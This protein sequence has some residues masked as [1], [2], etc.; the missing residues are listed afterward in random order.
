MLDHDGILAAVDA[1]VHD[2]IRVSANLILK[3]GQAEA[4]L[5][6]CGPPRGVERGVRSAVRE[7]AT[8]RQH[9]TMIGL[10]DLRRCEAQTAETPTRL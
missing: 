10:A 8:V 2:N 4:A 6:A 3:S 5:P 7:T 9:K 1:I